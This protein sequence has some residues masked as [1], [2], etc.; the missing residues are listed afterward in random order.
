MLILDTVW[1]PS[2]GYCLPKHAQEE[3]D[4]IRHAAGI[5]FEENESSEDDSAEMSNEEISLGALCHV[6]CSIW[7]VSG[8]LD[9][10]L[11]L[12]STMQTCAFSQPPHAFSV[13]LFVSALF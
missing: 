8:G 5:N 4:K 9:L 6:I 10:L 11:Q 2:A 7:Q 3:W 1:L 12:H 13:A